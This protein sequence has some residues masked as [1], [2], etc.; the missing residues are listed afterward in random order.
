MNYGK[1]IRL[2]TIC[3]W[4][5]RR[6]TCRPVLHVNDK[7]CITMSLKEWF[8]VG[9]KPKTPITGKKYE[10][11]PN[12]QIIVG[13]V[14]LYRIRALRDFGKVKAGD[15]GGF[16]ES[17][18][19]LSHEGNCWV[20]GQAHVSGD[21]QIYGNARVFEDARVYE[22]AQIG[23]NVRVFGTA[24]VW[25]YTKLGGRERVTGTLVCTPAG[26]KDE[27]WLIFHGLG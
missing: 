20:S 24:R 21:A 13:G 11:V 3:D 18:S 9:A 26:W 23:G 27:I 14:T 7:R 19:N 12:Q 1:L 17:E 4:T 6:G 25:G 8:R 22:H 16:V 15:F 2:V 5:S 10:L